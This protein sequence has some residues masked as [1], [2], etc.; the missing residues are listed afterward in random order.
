LNRV[1]EWTAKIYIWYSYCR[2]I[3]GNSSWW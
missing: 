3:H 2:Y 1:L